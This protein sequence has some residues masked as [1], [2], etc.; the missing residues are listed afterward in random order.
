MNFKTVVTE[1]KAYE[2]PPKMPIPRQGERLIIEGESYT[3][4]RVCYII[5][6]NNKFDIRISTSKD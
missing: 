3:I 4:T 6:D 5:N 2:L 1:N